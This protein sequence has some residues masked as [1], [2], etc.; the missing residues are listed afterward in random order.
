MYQDS[1]SHHLSF[2]NCLA[3]WGHTSCSRLGCWLDLSG[4]AFPH[5]IRAR[6]AGGP[7]WTFRSPHSRGSGP[8]RGRVR[9]GQI[10][11]PITAGPLGLDHWGRTSRPRLSPLLALAPEAPLPLQLHSVPRSPVLW[12]CH[13]APCCL[14]L[15]LTEIIV[16]ITEP[17]TL[18][19]AWVPAMVL[20]ALHM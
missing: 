4:S 19:I 8:E 5:G 3:V 14:S 1:T 7:S 15:C 17:L 9:G 18:G 2:L 16:L 20:K 11:Q 13:T 10:K 6:S 12:L